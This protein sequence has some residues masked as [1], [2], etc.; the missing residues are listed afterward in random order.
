M[1]DIG[2][3]GADGLDVFARITPGI[4]IDHHDGDGAR[5]DL[6]RFTTTAF[7]GR[8]IKTGF[9]TVN[10]MFGATSETA[11][12]GVG[13]FII[14]VNGVEVGVVAEVDVDGRDAIFARGFSRDGFG[15][16]GGQAGEDF[17]V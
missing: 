14:F 15:V 2:F 11:G 1:E 17:G 3:A 9:A 5:G 4:F 13:R 12:V 8:L 10:E 16:V 6:D 7:W